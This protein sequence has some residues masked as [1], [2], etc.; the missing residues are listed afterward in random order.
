MTPLNLDQLDAFSQLFSY[1]KN[2]LRLKDMMSVKRVKD[3]QAHTASLSY[4]FYGAKI[5]QNVLQLFQ[6][7]SEQSNLISRY[8][9]LTSGS[10]INKTENRAVLHHAVRSSSKTLYSDEFN[11]IKTFANG[12]HSGTITSSNG[13]PFKKVVQIGIGGSYLGPKSFLDALMPYAISRN[14][15][16]LKSDFISNIDPDS[17]Y[18]YLHAESS[19]FNETLWII[20]SKSGSTIETTENLNLL[21]AIADKKG[22]DISKNIVLVTQKKSRLEQETTCL[23][24]FY[25]DENIGGRFSVTSAVGALIVSL[26]FSPT[27]MESILKGSREIDENSL[28]KNCLTNLAMLNALNSIWERNCLNYSYKAVI[29]YSE[30]LNSFILHLQ[31]TDCESN[32][33]QVNQ[34][35]DFIP[36]QTGPMLVGSAGTNSQHSYFQKFHQGSDV[37][38]VQFIGFKKTQ[39]DISVEDPISD[40]FKRNHNLLNENLISQFFALTLGNQSRDPRKNFDGNRPCTLLICDQL[41]PETLGAL[42]SFYENTIMF[43]GFLWNVNSFDQE[44]VELGKKLATSLGQLRKQSTSTYEG[45]TQTEKLLQ[46]IYSESFNN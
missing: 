30:A 40:N 20:V 12:V 29:P 3:F 8:K 17:F 37:C 27:Y 6:K 45:N 31:Q 46:K 33:K 21:R 5:D 7:L 2:G 26:V 16:K 25:I 9:E 44:G 43:Q 4:H 41:N 35:G 34:N 28:N 1:A 36:Y 24:T 38:P 23:N 15:V 42:L 14:D 19:V 13:T 32:G 10:L 11:R 18:S 22:I 39:I